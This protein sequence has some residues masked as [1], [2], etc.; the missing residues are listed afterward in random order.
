MIAH[1]KFDETGGSRARNSAQGVDGLLVNMTDASWVAGRFGGALDFDGIEDF[2]SLPNF[3][4]ETR[5][6]TMV[7]WLKLN[8]SQVGYAGVCFR[9][10]GDDDVSGFGFSSTTNELGYHWDGENWDWHSGLVAPTGKWI[11]VAYVIRDAGATVYLGDPD[12]GVLNSASTTHGGLT[13]TFNGA[14]IGRDR[15]EDAG[16]IQN[17]YFKG[18][19][20]EL[21]LWDEAL[22]DQEVTDLFTLEAGPTVGFA[23]ETSGGVEALGNAAVDVVLTGAQAGQ[24]YTVAYATTGGTA[25]A[26]SDYTPASGV[27]TFSPGQTGKTINIAVAA[28]GMGEADE[29]IFIELSSA[30]GPGVVLGVSEHTYTIIDDQPAVSFAAA[31]S[32]AYEAATPA[33][34]DVVLT[35]A[36][37]QTVTVGYSAVGGTATNGPDYNLPAG[38]LTFGPGVT[39]QSIQIP[40]TEEATTEADETVIVALADPT[41]ASLGSQPQFTNTILD[42]E[43]GIFFNGLIWYHSEDSTRVMSV[44]LDGGLEIKVFKRDQ[45]IVHF[46]E[47]RLSQVGDVVEFSY[48]WRTDGRTIGCDCDNH[49]CDS[50]GGCCFD[51]DVMCVA[52]TGD[53][54]LGLFD[55]NGQ[56]LITDDNMDHTNSMFENYL[57]YQY[58]FFPHVSSD[59][60]GFTDSTGE[61]HAPGG[62]LK[63]TPGSDPA[64]LMNTDPSWSQFNSISGFEAP[65]GVFTPMTLR[66][67]RTSS[68]DIEVSMTLGDVTY[69]DTDTSSS[70]QPQK[71]DTFALLYRHSR[72]FDKLVLGAADSPRSGLPSPS[73]GATDVN[74][75]TVL[76]WIGGSVADSYDV[77]FGTGFGEVLTATK[78]SPEFKTNQTSESFD[79]G[80]LPFG[81]TYYWRIDDVNAMETLKG[82]VWSFTTAECAVWEDFESYSGSLAGTWDEAGGAWV[83]LDTDNSHSP[84]KSMKLEYSNTGSFRYCEAVRTFDQPQDYSGSDALG[85]YFKGQALNI[86]DRL[87]VRLEDTFGSTTEIPYAGPLADLQSTGWTAWGTSTADI[88][89]VDLSMMH[90]FS[91]G[92]GDRDSLPGGTSGI[93]WFDDM[94]LCRGTCRA[95]QGPAADETGDCMV[96][97]T[98]HAVKAQSWDDTAAKWQDY[99]VLAD[100]WLKERL[101]WP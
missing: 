76:T 99:K 68:S 22:L 31:A 52:G 77:Y 13:E 67:E 47:E 19:L 10:S 38:T 84:S 20:D 57:G 37:D 32:K 69:S 90:K 45:I 53:F 93:L 1:Y 88:S 70:N 63:K 58:R 65:I 43:P 50:P 87:Y 29:T 9:R 72:P 71:I 82:E 49:N 14:E 51:D 17:R 11:F 44:N 16:I 6:M 80:G 59:A 18:A 24:T 85:L 60:D 94:G 46:P 74:P 21:R 61:R 30:T 81:T 64:L 33:V 83:S 54:R 96:N 95:G 25:S 8:G 23:T 34:L 41:N 79:P 78:T 5:E 75:A 4:L 26:G 12:T 100:E 42:D 55:S 56:G 89:E 48:L 86:P 97:F 98:D 62:F 2:I 15:W 3:F 28:D 92:V 66:L 7:C 40:I 35:G 39:V 101:V 27:L 91:V 36:S 73:N